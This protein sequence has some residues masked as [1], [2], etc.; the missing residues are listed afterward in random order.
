MCEILKSASLFTAA[1][2]RDAHGAYMPERVYV[3]AYVLDCCESV[4]RGFLQLLSVFVLSICF[5]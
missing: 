4:C 1:S 2:W 3:N 5:L